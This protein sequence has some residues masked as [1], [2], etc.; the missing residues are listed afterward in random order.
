V[1]YREHSLL[2]K[3]FPINRVIIILSCI[4]S[5]FVIISTWNYGIGLSPDSVSYIATANNLLLGNGLLSFDAQPIIDWPPLYPVLLFLSSYSFGIGTAQSAILVNALL[6]GL[7]IYKSGMIL[8]KYFIS[9]SIIIIGLLAILFSIPIFSMTLWAWS[10][11]L[12]IFFSIWYINFLVSYIEKKN[13]I[14]FIMIVVI[15]ALAILTRYIG[16]FLILTTIISIILYSNES[17]KKKIISII[18]YQVLS[19]IPISIWLIR[20]YVISG[21]LFGK[22]GSTRNSFL[23]NI[24]LTI[25]KVL[26]WYIPEYFINLKIFFLIIATMTIVLLWL[27]V[28]KKIKYESLL[29]MLNKR[30]L[31]IL[32]LFISSYIF[33]LILLSSLKSFDPIDKRLLSPIYI[34]LIFLFLIILQEYYNRIYSF[35][36]YKLSRIAFFIFLILGF[37]NPFYTTLRTINYHYNKGAG[38]SGSSWP[39]NNTEKWLKDINKK[40][41]K[42]SVIYSNDPFAVYFLINICTKWSPVKSFGNSDEL[43]SLLTDWEGV[44]PPEKKSYLVW[45]RQLEFQ[46]RSLYT[47][48]ELAK[49][50]EM[51]IIDSS[52]LGSIY[53]VKSNNK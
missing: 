4:G 38:Y 35:R 52:D 10:E 1:N 46:R 19:V 30:I 28:S 41:I 31:I 49:I 12:F 24:Y 2:K 16:I 47:P 43:Y 15:T 33:I 22:R 53:F 21:T 8:T 9:N 20:N 39:K 14:S 6:F 26:G 27:S 5:S 37:A 17:T 25:E 36:Y 3:I 44:W 50:S 13:L 42:D 51:N 29:L 11:L 34:P 32:S 40:Y 18:V 23:S 7:I 48:E 45:F